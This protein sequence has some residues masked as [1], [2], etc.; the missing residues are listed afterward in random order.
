[1]TL[2]YSCYSAHLV[3]HDGAK[4]PFGPELV[5]GVVHKQQQVVLRVDEVAD[6]LQNDADKLFQAAAPGADAPEGLVQLGQPLLLSPDNAQDHV[7]TC[8]LRTHCN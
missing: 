3:V 7:T 4:C 2:K 6:G 5:A 1:M 8:Q